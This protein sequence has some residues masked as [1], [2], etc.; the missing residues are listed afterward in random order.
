MPAS[1]RKKR[2]YF[3]AHKLAL[4]PFGV[5]QS[6][7]RQAWQIIFEPMRLHRPSSAIYNLP[8]R[9]FL[10][11]WGTRDGQARAVSG[12]RCIF[13]LLVCDLLVQKIFIGKL[14]LLLS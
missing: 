1:L 14:Y 5:I 2:V 12:E 4:R 3:R 8:R 11:R 9:S 13:E 10:L 6:R 7:A